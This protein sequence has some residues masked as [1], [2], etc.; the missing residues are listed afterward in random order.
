MSVTAIV[1]DANM[2]ARMSSFVRDGVPA[3]L[4]DA[5]QAAA[6]DEAPQDTAAN[7]AAETNGEK[8]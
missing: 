5:S 3:E 2:I 7:G 4:D 8:R 1:L 6:A